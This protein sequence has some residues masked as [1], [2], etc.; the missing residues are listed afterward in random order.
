MKAHKRIYHKNVYKTFLHTALIGQII[1]KNFI[2]YFRND[3]RT[4]NDHFKTTI[5]NS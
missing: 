5:D 3:D 2:L 4:I 1:K